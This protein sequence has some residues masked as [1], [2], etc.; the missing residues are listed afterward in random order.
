MSMMEKDRLGVPK[1]IPLM[2]VWTLVAP[3]AL[4]TLNLETHTLERMVDEVLLHRLSSPDTTHC[5]IQL[6]FRRD[7]ATREPRA[8]GRY[9]VDY[10]GE[11]DVIVFEQLWNA[12]RARGASRH[13]WTRPVECSALADTLTKAIEVR[14]QQTEEAHV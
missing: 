5:R 2:G 10:Y 9:I 6:Q 12:S 3:E 4:L 8:T 11:D 14:K 1:S 7:K 13:P